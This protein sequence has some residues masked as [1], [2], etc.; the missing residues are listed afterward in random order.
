MNTHVMVYD[1]FFFELLAYAPQHL[2]SFMAEHRPRGHRHGAAI[3]F[4]SFRGSV[5][6]LPPLL[7]FA[8]LDPRK[9]D[10]RLGLLEAGKKLRFDC[11]CSCSSGAG[12]GAGALTGALTSL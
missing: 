2:T 7:L 12:T 3:H 11:Q 4:F 10:I 9:N 5:V 1:P 6:S 8:L